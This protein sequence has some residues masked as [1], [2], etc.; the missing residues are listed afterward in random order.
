MK[1]NVLVDGPDAR[2]IESALHG[3]LD[4]LNN[5]MRGGFRFDWPKVLGSRIPRRFLRTSVPGYRYGS[6]LSVMQRLNLRSHLF[7]G[8][9]AVNVAL[10]DGLRLSAWLKSFQAD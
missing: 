7:E 3:G 2:C 9:L 8:Q 1:P 10:I 4:Q 6:V 5:S